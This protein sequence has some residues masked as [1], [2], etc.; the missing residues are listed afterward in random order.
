MNKFK[1][2]TGYASIISPYQQKVTAPTRL[3][4][5]KYKIFPIINETPAKSD[6]A[7]PTYSAKSI[8][9]PIFLFA[10]YMDILRKF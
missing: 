2:K 7:Y 3:S 4:H 1:T 5:L 6:A 9:N 8:Q 10:K